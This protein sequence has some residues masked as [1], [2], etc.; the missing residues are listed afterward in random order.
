[1]PARG[2]ARHRQTPEGAAPTVP[3][4]PAV[5]SGSWRQATAASDA[6]PALRS[7]RN[8]LDATFHCSLH[9]PPPAQGPRSV[10]APSAPWAPSQDSPAR[11]AGPIV[12]ASEC[13]GP[14]PLCTPSRSPAPASHCLSL[15]PLGPQGLSRKGQAC[16]PRCHVPGPRAG[17]APA[18]LSPL[19]PAAGEL[20]G[21]PSARTPL[22]LLARAAPQSSALPGMESRG[23]YTVDCAV[24]LSQ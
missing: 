7:V 9:T 13:A 5:G 14:S 15:W 23:F 4:G 22:C 2:P 19:S 17:A 10:R 8:L 6:R 11:S 1:M 18:C 21:P 20:T 24:T 3:A 12:D 16:S